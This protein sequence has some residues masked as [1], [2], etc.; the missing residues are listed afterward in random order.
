MVFLSMFQV[1]DY[2]AGTP[3][4]VDR[5]QFSEGTQY[6]LCSHAH[7]DHLEGLTPTWRHGT[8][9]CS[10]VTARLLCHR[11]GDELRQ[12]M[13][14]LEIGE[15]AVFDHTS[16]PSFSLTLIEA[17][18]CPGACMFLVEGAFGTLL[19]TGDFQYHPSIIDSS[20]LKRKRIDYLIIDNTFCSPCFEF[21]TLDQTVRYSVTMF[22]LHLHIMIS[23]IE[24]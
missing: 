14:V 3:I 12:V 13:R 9:V 18:H 22:S 15:S 11:F 21:Q 19:H 23:L 10:R 16:H 7:A 8:L 5:F 24:V 1:T 20:C 6:Y 17:N 4:R 2:L